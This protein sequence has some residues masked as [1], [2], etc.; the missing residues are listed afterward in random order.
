MNFAKILFNKRVFLLLIFL[1]SKS[2]F[3]L[4]FLPYGLLL[5]PYVGGDIFIESVG[6]SYSQSLG[7]GLTD[8]VQN[9]TANAGIRIHNNI[10][11]E[12][13]Y[14]QFQNNKFTKANKSYYLD[15]Q[16]FYF[17]L[18]LYY[19]TKEILGSAIE[20]YASIGA[21][22]LNAKFTGSIP[23][24]N[25]KVWAGKFGAGLQFRLI[26]AS[27]IRFGVEYYKMDF[28]YVPISDILLLK[29]GFSMYFL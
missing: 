27:S 14:S 17:D 1:S 20:L 3:S 28:N 19:P 12:I 10:G 9:L 23:K 18:L 7:S 29:L 16:N 22:Y 8:R 11:L 2:A 6:S 25:E 21:A 13:G 5:K 24:A 4:S 15:S 26:G